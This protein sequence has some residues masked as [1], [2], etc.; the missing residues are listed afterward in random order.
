LLQLISTG[1]GTNSNT[2]GISRR[3]RNKT[4]TY[5]RSARLKLSATWHDKNKFFI[6]FLLP[7][8]NE[9]NVSLLRLLLVEKFLS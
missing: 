6:I 1:R 9:L 3:R 4:F 7:Q 8:M 2:L 5:L